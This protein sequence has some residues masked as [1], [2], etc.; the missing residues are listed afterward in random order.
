MK[1]LGLLA[2]LVIIYFILARETP[3]AQVKEA[4]A[5]TEAAPLT[6]G[7]REP[8]PSAGS[9]LKRPL[10]RTHEVLETVKARNGDGEF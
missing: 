4:I 8:A 5:Q 7:S 1:Y 3:V 10:D 9:S 2:A 6:T